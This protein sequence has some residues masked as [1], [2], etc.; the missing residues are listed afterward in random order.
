MN[1]TYTFNDVLIRPTYSEVSTRKDVD[2]TS[3]FGCFKLALPIISANMKH[4]TGPSMA[5]E[6][7]LNGGMGILHRFNTI[8]Q[9]IED[10]KNVQ[11][12]GVSIGVQEEDKKR[13][14]ALY[15]IGA[16]I[17]CIDVA[18]GY[19]KKVKDMLHWLSVVKDIYIIAGNIA[20]PEAAIDLSFWGAHAIKIGIGPGSMCQT[21]KNTGVGVPQLY[22]L[23]TCYDELKNRG[24]KTKIIADGGIKSVGDVAK[25]MK[26]ADATMIGSFISG[27]TECPGDVYKNAHGQYYKVYAGSASGENKTSNGQPADFVE[28]MV[29]EV[30]FRGHVKY[31]L[32]EIREGLQ[33]AFSY[34]GA[35]NLQEFKTKCTFNFI[36]GSGRTES[37]I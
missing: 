23:Q 25:A 12:A 9:S 27:T 24:Y 2:L 7:S 11:C 36:S 1:N 30:P 4:I 20:T 33:S 3:D 19:C 32:K 8:E 37:K 15:E 35:T 14:H 13:F 18:N 29:A 21:R 26:Y 34:V 6:M 16:R 28:G 17:F 22:A 31:I 5:I 10:F